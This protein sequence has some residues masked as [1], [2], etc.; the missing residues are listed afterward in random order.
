[1]WVFLKGKKKTRNTNVFFLW[2][3]NSSK[4]RLSLRNLRNE[5][6]SIL[7]GIYQ[8][9]LSTMLALFKKEN[10]KKLTDLPKF[11]PLRK[12]SKCYVRWIFLFF[13]IFFC[14]FFFYIITQWSCSASGSLREMTNS[15]PGPLPQKLPMSHHLSIT[16]SNITSSLFLSVHFL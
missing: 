9:Q 1:M 13:K 14:R 15:N 6:H 8:Y 10:K 16:I 11:S 3:A 12:F 4:I 5:K 2:S 7:Y